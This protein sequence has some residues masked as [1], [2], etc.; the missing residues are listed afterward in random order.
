MS[1]YNETYE[2]FHDEFFPEADKENILQDLKVEGLGYA[3][4]IE[5][6]SN[7][8]NAMLAEGDLDIGKLARLN[9]SIY[10]NANR[11][12]AML[13]AGADYEQEQSE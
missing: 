1:D 11:M 12:M 13:N 4:I 7:M 2:Y 8:I 6:A 9:H 10:K 5:G 3:Q